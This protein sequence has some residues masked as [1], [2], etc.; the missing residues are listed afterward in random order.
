MS[1]FFGFDSS[2]P[3]RRGPPTQQQ[4]FQGFQSTNNDQS[5]AQS[6]GPVDDDLAVYNWGDGNGASLMEGDEYNDETFGG[7]GPMCEYRSLTI[8][9]G[10]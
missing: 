8:A 9:D 7:S 6:S 2:L 5:F 3:E 4:Q 10:E 1:G